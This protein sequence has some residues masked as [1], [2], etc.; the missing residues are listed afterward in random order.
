[1][2]SNSQSLSK[3]SF[4]ANNSVNKLLSKLNIGDINTFLAL[5]FVLLLFAK[6]VMFHY[7][8]FG[9]VLVSSLWKDPCE[10]IMF[11]LPKL[12]IPLFIGAFVFISKRY[13]WTLIISLLVDTWCV[14][15][16]IYLKTYD[17]FFT[18]DTIFLA[19]NLDGAWSSI[20]PYINWQVYSFII[21][22]LLWLILLVYVSKKKNAIYIRNFK[23]FV[24]IEV[25]VLLI[26]MINNKLIYG[27]YDVDDNNEKVEE[28]SIKKGDFERMT[29]G[30]D[31]KLKKDRIMVPYIP[32]T[33]VLFEATGSISGGKNYGWN[34]SYVRLQSIISYL[35]AAVIYYFVYPLKTGEIIKLNDNDIAKISRFINHFSV[36]CNNFNNKN[37]IIILVESLESWPLEKDIDGVNV[38]PNLRNLIVNNHVLYCDKIKSQTLSG[39]SGDGQMIINTGLLPISGSV[40][41][42]DYGNNIYPNIAHFYDN[43]TIV[44]PWTHV[45]NQDTMT[46]RY[47]Y[48]N[49]IEPADTT[50]E[51]YDVISNLKSV[52]N[53]YTKPSCTMAITV[54]TH[55]PFDRIDKFVDLSEN[56]PNII[57]KYLNC[58]CYTDKCLG[59]IINHIE[60]DTALSNSM[61][62]ITGDH[63]VFKPVMFNEFEKY[64]TKENLSCAT[65]KNY[66]P[67]I[68]YSPEIEGNIHVTDTCY[69]MDVFPTI[70]HLIGAEDYYWHGFGVN[71]MDSVARHDRPITEQEAYRLSDLMIRSDYFRNYYGK[72]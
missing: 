2:S 5:L 22:S 71:V 4:N 67:L 40:T 52:L 37:L 24:I 33:T 10:F 55:L 38:M 34:K 42:W 70:L 26:T 68:I 13:W 23:I 29:L 1:M 59:E 19:N 61:I 49:L 48:L 3:S 21:L 20:L 51:D 64:L 58:L 25:I 35:P 41:C 6:N 14:A 17:M 12:S 66:C 65:G 36:K 27:N 72:Q 7:Y 16:M 46:V 63:T 50:W 47:S 53:N 30:D 57:S 69:Q 56:T 32:F 8:A 60:T 31:P 54:S 62:V 45:W 18:I 11:Y 15:N 43:S 9:S 28:M 44:N 39:N